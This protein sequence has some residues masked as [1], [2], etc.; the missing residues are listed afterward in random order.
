MLSA[1]TI[2][3]TGVLFLATFSLYRWLLPKPI[4]G[5]PFN[6][7]ATN[8]IFGDIPSMLNHLKTHKTV[9]DWV[10]NHS[11][12]HNSPIVQVFANLFGKQWVI[13]NDYR[14]AQ[15][16]LMRRTKE[17]D[18]PD[19]LSDIFWGLSPDHHL[20]KPS[21]DEFR[22]QRKLMQDLMSPAFLNG[23][24]APQVHENFLDLIKFWRE[25]IRLSK[26]HPFSVKEDVYDTALEAIWAAVFGIEETATITRNQ[27]DLLSRMEQ[28]T[29]SPMAD[30]EA[31]FPRAPAPAAFDAILRLADSFELL[32]KSPFPRAQGFIM[33]YMPSIR[34]NLKLKDEVIINQISK[35]E[36]KLADSKDKEEKFATAVDH[37]LRREAIA[38]ERQKRAPDYQS[39]VMIAE[40]FGLLLAGHDTTSTTLL[41]A[42][43]LLAANQ[44]IQQKLRSELR[45]AFA[46]AHSQARVPNA[47]EIATTQNHYLDACL[48]EI[49]R[50]SRTATIPSRRAT[51]D[52]VVLGHVIPK[53][54]SVLF[55]ATGGGI[56][57]PNYKIDDKLRSQSYRNADGGKV[58]VW[59]SEDIEEFKPERWLVHNKDT[60]ATVFDSQA[61]PHLTFGLGPRSCFGRKLAYLELRLGIV[62]ILWSFKL[63]PVPEKYASWEAID[64]LTHAPVQAYVQLAEA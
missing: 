49:I 45:I 4:P 50:C 8:S 18:K 41:W 58:G 48:E 43:K 27:I 37:M 38:A 55:M 36:K 44:N 33:R 10:L 1:S 35:A 26:G 22:F 29:L 30:E 31:T 32:V 51:Q 3:I 63:Q 57:Q 21:N 34:R 46:A 15:D 60:G 28:T 42:I 23:V 20:V 16:I 13:I 52:A 61:G 53:G 11:T 47:Q 12:R 6:P 14:E 2:T 17:F 25:K 62:L 64:Q 7:E 54:T 59:N 5:I 9:S 24:A 40:L 19:L 56:L 39:K